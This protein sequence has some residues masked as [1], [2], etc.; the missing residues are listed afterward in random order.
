[1]NLYM[2]TILM[3]QRM[4]IL[5]RIVSNFAATETTHNTGPG[6]PHWRPRPQHNK[7]LSTTSSEAIVFASSCW[8]NRVR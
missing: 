8:E 3:Y 7:T 5:Q 1:M 2:L 6:E 4:P